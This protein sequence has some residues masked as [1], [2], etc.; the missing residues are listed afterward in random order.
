MNQMVRIK[1]LIMNHP[2]TL[3]QQKKNLNDGANDSDA[4]ELDADYN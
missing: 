3:T 2:N 1:Y 4:T